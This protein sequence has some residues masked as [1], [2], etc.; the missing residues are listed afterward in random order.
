VEEHAAAE[1]G[2]ATTGARPRLII[3]GLEGTATELQLVDLDGRLAAHSYVDITMGTA[4]SSSRCVL[5]RPPTSGSRRRFR[6]ILRTPS[7]SQGTVQ[8]KDGRDPRL[9]VLRL[10]A[11]DLSARQIGEELF[12]SHNTVRSHMRAIYR[13]LGVGSRADATARASALGLFD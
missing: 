1:A 9:A 5:R 4:G 11:S 10:L 13:K 12:L 7:A 8:R 2:R 3:E 6:G